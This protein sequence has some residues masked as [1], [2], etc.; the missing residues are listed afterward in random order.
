MSISVADFWKLLVE[1]RLLSVDEARQAA[2]EL[3][4]LRPDAGKDLQQVAKSLIQSGKITLYQ[5]KV[6]AG[7]KPGPFVYGDYLVYDR[8]EAPRLSSLLR[9]RHQPTKHPVCLAFLTG[10]ASPQ[11]LV[12]LVPQLAV[13]RQASQ[14][15]PRLSAC[16]EFVDAGVAKFL[17]V[18]NLRGNSLDERLKKPDARLS[19]AAACRLVRLTALGLGQLHSM[20]QAH[21]HVRPANV[22]LDESGAAK[23]LQFPLIGDPLSAKAP[24]ASVEAQL[25]YLAPELANPATLADARSDVYSLGCLLYTLLAGQPPFARGDRQS[26]LER[27]AKEP[28]APITQL[29]PQT[30]A[31]LAQVLGYLL[32]KEPARRYP[33]ANA[34]AEALQAYSGA[35]PQATAEPT[36]AAYHAWLDR[37]DQAPAGSQPPAVA[38]QSANGNGAGAMPGQAVP[39][40]AVAAQAIAARG[41]TTSPMAATPMAQ[42]AGF[43][44]AAV[45]VATSP[46]QAQPVHAGYPAHARPVGAVAAAM[47]AI[48]VAAPA[49]MPAAGEGSLSQRRP[50]KSGQTAATIGVIAVAVAA[51]GGVV[52][53]LNS[54]SGKD[55]APPTDATGALATTGPQQT[56]PA[57]TSEKEAVDPNSLDAHVADKDS[58]QK[59]PVQGIGGPIWQSP[60]AGQPLNLAWLPPGVQVVL[61]LRPAELSQQPEWQKLTDKRTLGTLAAWL[62][63]DLPKATGKTPDLLES[64]VVGL[65][66]GSPGPPKVALVA[67]SNE[68]F[69]LDELKDAW[70]EAKAEEIEGQVIHVQSGRA[71]YVPPSGADKLLV[72]AP[73][74]ELRDMLKTG[75]E[76]PPLRREVEILA[77]SSDEERHL[78]LLAA[79]NFPLTDGKTLF[80]DEGVKLLAPLRDFLEMQDTDGKLEMTKALLFS[81]HLGE[82]LFLELRLYDN[83]GRPAQSAAREFQHRVDALPKEVSRYVR[84]LQLS[85]YSKPILWDYKDQLDLLHKYTRLGI[86]GKQI[87]LRAYLPSRAAHNLALGAHLAL[88]EVPGDGTPVAVASTQGSAKPLTVAE[89]LKKKTTLSFPRNTLEQSMKLLGDDI[90]VEIVILGND[91]RDEGITKNQS[92]GLDEKEQPADEILRKIMKLANPD[93]KLVY[94]IK[95]K[96]GGGEDVLYVT[97]RAAA[98]KR[99][100]KL[101]PELEK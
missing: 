20:G 99:G 47:P 77:E 92:F 66:D 30:P 44:R 4:R 41:P 32:Q 3:N 72:I 76:A 64:V 25:D 60:T 68:E 71:F 83:F 94:T 84:D 35:D 74:V 7:G 75:G 24:P 42:P 18:E 97:T 96:E 45:A 79:P 14:S 49:M 16:H 54:E 29:N 43:P 48:S 31:A 26:K 51:L 19:I 53:F 93:G 67:R 88:L 55:L 70:A 91:L 85:P 50:R 101:P 46:H 39:V 59:E 61:A 56:S 89:R 36:L 87:V 69:N 52:L 15:Q 65:L 80:V 1:S 78:T 8:V 57:A 100:D 13:A 28:P 95:P 90:G 9:A 5:A 98:K 12:K 37:S 82:S 63:D 11:T 2:D 10:Q 6:L 73:A 38:T 58:G 17:V 81:C 22:W 27:H 33:D 86:E 40:Q 21:G 23:L 62:T 34:V